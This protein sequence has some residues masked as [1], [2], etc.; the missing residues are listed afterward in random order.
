M[1]EPA[2]TPTG[3]GGHLLLGG[4]VALALSA[5]LLAVGYFRG[6]RSEAAPAPAP[7]PAA[8]P[9]EDGRPAASA[10]VGQKVVLVQ[11]DNK[12]ETTWQALGLLVD[13]AAAAQGARLPI[14]WDVPKAVEVLAGIRD[15]HGRPPINARVDLLSGGP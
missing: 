11:G 3:S 7:P 4:G 8:Q 13:D 1:N 6:G 10:L 14:T 2:R 9:R 15:E 12:V 5:V